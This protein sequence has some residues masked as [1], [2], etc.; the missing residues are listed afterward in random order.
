MQNFQTRQIIFYFNQI[1]SFDI[2]IVMEMTSVVSKSKVE[3]IL[4]MFV[5]LSLQERHSTF[6]A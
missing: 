1:L 6:L 2:A 5:E 4:V 3:L